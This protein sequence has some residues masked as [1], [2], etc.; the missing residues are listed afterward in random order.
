MIWLNPGERITLTALGAAALAGLG[1]T[2]W[3]QR[4]PPI[5]VQAGPAPSYA[6]WDAMVDQARRVDLNRA[7][8][9]ELERLPEVGPS[10][11]RRIVDYRRQHGAFRVAEELLQVPGIGEKT[12]EILKGYIAISPSE[13]SQ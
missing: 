8:A 5:T 1:V 12:Y 3:Q 13:I 10:L 11:A 9:E 6:R 4:R 7:T 2:V